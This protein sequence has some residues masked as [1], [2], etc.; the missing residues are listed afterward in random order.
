MRELQE[1]IEWRIEQRD[2]ITF[3][4]F[5]ELALY[6]PKGGYYTKPLDEVFQVDFYTAPAAHPAFGSLICLQVYQVW[7]LL[8]QPDPFWVI[9]MGAGRGVLSHDLIEYS[10]YLPHG[11]D[12][13]LNYI[14]LDYT[15]GWGVEAALRSTYSVQRLV[16]GNV[17]L[18]GITGC[19]LSN[20]LLDAFPVH[21]ITM[22]KGVLQEI[23]VTLQDGHFVEKI[24]QPS[25]PALERRLDNLGIVLPDGFSTE[26]NLTLTAWVEE[27]AF[28]LHKG[29]VITVDYGYKSS[30]LYSTSRARGTLSCFYRHLQNDTPYGHIGDQDITA[31]VDFTSVMNI[32]E[33]LGLQNLGITTQRSFLIN[34]G[35][36]QMLQRLVQLNLDQGELNANRMAM[37][38]IMRPGGLGDFKVLVQSKGIGRPDLWGLE[39]KAELEELVSLLPVMLLE[40]HHQPIMTGKYPHLNYGLKEL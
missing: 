9:E 6:W 12:A 16:T 2:E 1:E 13:S 17:P 21:R 3:A 22:R 19:F 36:Q 24:G 35:A 7:L 29:L 37:L 14:C 8:G 18:R 23:Y 38:D 20:E 32:S 26:I 34:L 27:L 4:E 33:R 31:Q 30:D 39:S 11:F 28:A 5:M 40:D 25:T 10:R 15:A